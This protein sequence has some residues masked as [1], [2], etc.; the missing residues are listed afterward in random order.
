MA[1]DCSLV[2]ARS[3]DAL[4]TGPVDLPERQRTLRATVAWSVALRVMTGQLRWP[5]ADANPVG[6]NQTGRAGIV[7][8]AMQPRLRTTDGCRRWSRY[9]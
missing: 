8:A 4:G 1:H 3:L 6:A 9:R 2:H 7:S 5:L